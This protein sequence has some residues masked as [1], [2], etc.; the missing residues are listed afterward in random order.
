M[1]YALSFGVLKNSKLN[2]KKL[3]NFEKKSEYLGIYS[4]PHFFLAENYLVHF[5]CLE[6]RFAIATVMNFTWAFIGLAKLY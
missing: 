2:P 3:T 4:K 1:K 6:D 5:L